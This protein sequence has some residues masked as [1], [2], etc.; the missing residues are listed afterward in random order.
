[1]AVN[2]MYFLDFFM[3]FNRDPGLDQGRLCFRHLE[4]GDLQ[5]WKATSSTATKQDAESFHEKGGLIPPGYRIKNFKRWQVSTIPIFMPSNPGV[6]GNFYKITPHEIVTDKGGKRG[7]FGIHF[8]GNVPGS[9]GCPV[10]D[11]ERFRLFEEEMKKLAQQNIVS[12]PLF[13]TYS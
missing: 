6:A 2:N 11:G 5:V 9:L 7:D 13:V 3:Q 1:M 10:L 4:M 12:I 8:D